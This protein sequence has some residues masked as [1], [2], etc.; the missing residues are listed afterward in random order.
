MAHFIP[1]P[2]TND[3]SYIVELYFKKIIRHHDVHKTV[4]FDRDSKFLSHFWRSLCKL[5]G[6][7]LFFSMSPTN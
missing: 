1:D 3:A 6:T 7:R 4:V 2:K 5:L